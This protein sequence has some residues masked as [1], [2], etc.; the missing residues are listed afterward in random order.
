MG[1]T[2]P[3]AGAGGREEG[4][5][6]VRRPGRREGVRVL[7]GGSR[8]R[9][10]GFSTAGHPVP[11][12]TPCPPRLLSK[13]VACPARRLIGEGM[14]KILC[15]FHGGLISGCYLVRARRGPR[16]ACAHAETVS[17]DAPR[18]SSRDETPDG[19]LL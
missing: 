2:L 13:R 11:L 17:R 4:K 12:R 3:P 8:A 16:R 6:T 19:G 18:R 10:T 9:A 14:K 15:G 5:Q 1:G 7:A